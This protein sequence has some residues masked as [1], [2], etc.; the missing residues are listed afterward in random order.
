MQLDFQQDRLLD[1]GLEL[2]EIS[3]QTGIRTAKMLSCTSEF[4]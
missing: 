4:G 1:S 2:Q 3:Y